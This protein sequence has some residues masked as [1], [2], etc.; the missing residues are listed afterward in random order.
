MNTKTRIEDIKRPL[1]LGEEYLVPCLV[2]RDSS[3]MV[4]SFT[5]VFSTPHT[6]KATKE[7]KRIVSNFKLVEVTK[8]SVSKPIESEK[9]YKKQLEKETKFSWSYLRNK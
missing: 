2:K 6:D 9:D 1:K 3:G 7:L 8:I 4:L 5:P